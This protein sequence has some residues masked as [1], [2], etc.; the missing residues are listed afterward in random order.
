MSR[1]LKWLLPGPKK[2]AGYAADGIQK[3]VN[4]SGY[5]EQ[6]AKYGELADRATSVQARLADWLRDGRID[7]VEKDELVELLTP[8]M[9]KLEELI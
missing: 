2:L 3:A 6:I 4:G 8:L 7:D 1:I 9:Q 5:T